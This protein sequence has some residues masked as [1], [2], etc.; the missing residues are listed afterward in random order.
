M[1]VCAWVRAEDVR[2]GFA[3]DLEGDEIAD[4]EK[5]IPEFQSGLSVVE[6]V[7]TMEF[8]HVYIKLKDG[9]AFRFPAD[10]V[11]RVGAFDDPP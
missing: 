5:D 4:P 6:L 7:D 10:H 2:P 9:E 3:L 11:M 8:N 1:A